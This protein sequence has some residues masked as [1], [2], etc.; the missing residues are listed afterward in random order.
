VNRQEA[1]EAILTLKSAGDMSTEIWGAM[2]WPFEA[3][4]RFSQFPKEQ[5]NANLAKLQERIRNSR[6][7]G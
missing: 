5:A 6:E 3:F 7:G 2:G 4:L 1:I